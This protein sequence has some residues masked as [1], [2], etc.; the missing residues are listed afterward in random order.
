V[1][2]DRWGN[3]VKKADQGGMGSKC[4]RGDLRVSIAVKRHHDHC[5][6]Y[7]GKHFIG[8]GLQFRGLI[9]YHHDGKHGDTQAVMIL[10]KE[11]KV[12]YIHLQAA[13]V[14]CELH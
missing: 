6:S 13:E 14:N 5:N 7:K 10:E 3:G 4:D 2:K 1:G 9:H 11:L 8:A 12:L